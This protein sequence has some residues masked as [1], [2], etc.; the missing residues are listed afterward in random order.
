MG[1]DQ[2]WAEVTAIWE[3]N[4]WLY[5]FA[6]FLLGLLALPALERLT[7]GL[8]EVLGDL[9]PEAAGIVF[10]VLIIDRLA[11]NRSREQLKQRLFNEMRSA[12]V[13]QGTAALAWLRREGWIAEDTLVGADLHRA[14]WENAYIGGLNLNG[15]NLNGAVL[16][17]VSNQ[18]T[19]AAG[20][21]EAAPVSLVGASFRYA[22]LMECVLVR[23]DLSKANLRK[24]HLKE[25]VL[26][27]TTLRCANLSEADL[28]GA[29][30]FG[31][32]LTGAD[33]RGT[34]LHQVRWV[35]SSGENVTILPDGNPWTENTDMSIFTNTES[36]TQIQLSAGCVS[37]A[38]NS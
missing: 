17:N 10:T 22:H 6:G 27:N 9:F 5:G 2:R 16:T 15:A 18:I 29:K 35:D 24:A 12:A 34:Q 13:G 25:A 32:D 8:T 31:V 4:R 11:E 26:V 33:L 23:A 30:L 20:D 37:V 7:G 28:T 14:N 1:A 36:V 38:T 21:T 19:N 3:T